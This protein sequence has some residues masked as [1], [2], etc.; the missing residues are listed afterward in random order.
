MHLF[1]LGFGFILIVY[2][3]FSVFLQHINYYCIIPYLKH[4]NRLW[5]KMTLWISKK[6]KKKVKNVHVTNKSHSFYQYQIWISEVINLCGFMLNEMSLSARQMHKYMFRQ[7]LHVCVA[8]NRQRSVLIGPKEWC[9]L[10][11]YI[12]FTI[13]WTK[14]Y[15]YVNCTLSQLS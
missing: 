7:I 9:A 14:C 3:L 10:W 11:C 4:Y 13:C 15:W 6:C 2:Q 1:A 5:C 8:S 12:D